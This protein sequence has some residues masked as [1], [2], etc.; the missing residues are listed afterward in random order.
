MPDWNKAT[1]EKNQITIS[2]HERGGITID[3]RN[4]KNNNEILWIILCQINGQVPWKTQST[5][6]YSRRNR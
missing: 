1:R 3:Y 6:A 2:R 5:K 4:V